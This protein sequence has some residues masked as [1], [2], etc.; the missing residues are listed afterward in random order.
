MRRERDAADRFFACI[1][2]N[3]GLTRVRLR[4]RRGADEQFA[5]AATAR[6]LKLMAK[7]LCDP[8]EAPA[9]A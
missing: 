2:H 5:L 3:D 7:L 9:S 6:N 1:K 8:T 4:G